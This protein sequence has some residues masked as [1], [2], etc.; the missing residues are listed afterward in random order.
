MTFDCDVL[1]CGGGVAGL[2]AAAL[3]GAAGFEVVCVDPV[4]P[5]TAPDQPGADLRTTALLQPAQTLLD[6]AGIWS[7]FGDAPA[8]L[9]IMRIVEGVTNEKQAPL[10]RDFE[11]SDIS[12]KPF[13]WNVPNWLLRREMMAH[14][15]ALDGVTFLP[16]TAVKSLFT[17]EK[18]ARVGLSDGRRLRTRLVV[19]ADGRESCVRGQAGI[20]ITRQR[21]CQK[22]HRFSGTQAAPPHN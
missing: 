18:E 14:I 21:D 1:I 16:G 11:S 9:N 5:V 3:F 17:R 13:G 15:A 4:P 20:G 7:R 8:P 2:S 10:I 22:A 19:A 12:D 6:R